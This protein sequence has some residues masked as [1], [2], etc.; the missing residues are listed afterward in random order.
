MYAYFRH[1]PT[2]IERTCFA[3]ASDPT[4]P[5]NAVAK[6]GELEPGQLRVIGGVTY[7]IFNHY[8]ARRANAYVIDV[9]PE[10]P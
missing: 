4:R 9:E 1:G 2:V 3:P 5:A 8:F 6:M 7:R 10:T